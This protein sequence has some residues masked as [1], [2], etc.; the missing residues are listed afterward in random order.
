MECVVACTFRNNQFRSIL[1]KCFSLEKAT[2]ENLEDSM[3]EIVSEFGKSANCFVTTDGGPNMV[4]AFKENRA[5]CFCHSFN[6]A[7]RHMGE[8][9]GKKCMKYGLTRKERMYISRHFERIKRICAKV[10]CIR[11]ADF[12]EWK[13][14]MRECNVDFDMNIPMPETVSP[15]RWEY[16][17]IQM[18]WLVK[19]GNILYR[20]VLTKGAEGQFPSLVSTLHTLQETAWIIFLLEHSM[21][22]LMPSDKPT[23]HLVIP[24]RAAIYTILNS[25]PCTSF[26]TKEAKVM[27]KL[28]RHELEQGCPSTLN[29]VYRHSCQ[30]ATALHPEAAMLVP[31]E[32]LEVCTASARQLFNDLMNSNDNANAQLR[33]NHFDDVIKNARSLDI[34]PISLDD[35]LDYLRPYPSKLQLKGDDAITILMID[36]KCYMRMGRRTV[37]IANLSTRNKCTVKRKKRAAVVE[38]GMKGTEVDIEVGEEANGRGRGRGRGTCMSKKRSLDYKRAMKARSG[39]YRKLSSIRLFTWKN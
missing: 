31:E 36:K 32:L 8:T 5:Q 39:K 23:I 15:T 20:Y 25:E 38:E 10:R 27:I 22:L 11:V 29:Y 24:I 26:K 9:N 13:N 1:C 4:A 3:K 7:I 19:Y 6:T 28:L 34:H 30:A 16:M 2:A 37:H 35:F 14:E 18:R 21:A 17:A 33:N 12:E